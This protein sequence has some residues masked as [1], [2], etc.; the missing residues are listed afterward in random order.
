MKGIFKTALAAMILAAVGSGASADDFNPYVLK[1]VEHLASKHSRGGYNISKAFTHDIDYGGTGTVKATDPTE[2]MCVAGVAEVIMYATK[3][4][5][6]ENNDK[7]VF[8]K[9]PATAWTRGNLTSLKANIFM[10][11]K[12]GSNGTGHT[13]SQF[14][15]GEERLFKDLKAGDFINLNRTSRSGHSVVFLGYVQRDLTVTQDFNPDVVGFKYFSAQGKG[16]PDAGF[17][18]R[19]AFFADFCP[20]NSPVPRDCGVIRSNN[21]ILLN[22]GRMWHP[23][24]WKYLDAVKRKVNLARSAIEDLMPEAS[25]GTIDGILQGQLD[26]ELQMSASRQGALTGETTD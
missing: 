6:T 12:T 10:F 18:Y 11:D 7:A 3:I 26:E 8:T 14:D 22:A 25:R 1:A 21:R 23:D 5:A 24:D 15:I 16:K 19:F 4:Y 9:I 20:A 2:T 13:L 17:A